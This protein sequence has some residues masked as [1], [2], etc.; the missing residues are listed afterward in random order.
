MQIFYV[1]HFKLYTL[2]CSSLKSYRKYEYMIVFIQCSSV[3]D[4]PKIALHYI[5]LFRKFKMLQKIQKPWLIIV[6]FMALLNC[7]LMSRSQDIFVSRCHMFQW[8]RTGSWSC[9]DVT[10]T[11][12]LKKSL[13]PL[14]NFVSISDINN[15]LFVLSLT[16]LD[17]NSIKF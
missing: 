17:V 11:K 5:V 6:I 13:S 10:L 16:V 4:S 9:R 3:L 2:S 8:S 1:T 14:A 7:N 12:Q 15:F